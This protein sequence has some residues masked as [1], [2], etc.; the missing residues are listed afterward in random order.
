MKKEFEL[1]GQEFIELNKLL[2][3]L[4]L[5][6]T[7]GEA[8]IVIEEGQVKVNNAVEYRKRNKLRPGDKVV[9]RGSEIS[10]V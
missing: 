5:V 2:K 8:K 9:F 4:S 1:N 10:I 6:E 7:G 3:L